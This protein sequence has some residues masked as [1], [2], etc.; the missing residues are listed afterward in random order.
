[1]KKKIFIITLIAF[2]YVIFAGAIIVGGAGIFSLL[3]LAKAPKGFIR[4]KS[5]Y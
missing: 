2:L 1:M 3:I 4:K 5:K